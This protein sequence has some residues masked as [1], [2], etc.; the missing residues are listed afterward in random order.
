MLS[1]FSLFVG[2][3]EGMEK[4]GLLLESERKGQILKAMSS[5]ETVDI[6][7]EVRKH[8][9]SKDKFKAEN[10]RALEALENSIT[11]GKKRRISFTKYFTTLLAQLKSQQKFVRS[12]LYIFFRLY[13]VSVPPP[14][15][16]ASCPRKDEDSGAAGCSAA[17]L[18]EEPQHNGAS[19]PP[20]PDFV[21][22]LPF[23]IPRMFK[24]YVES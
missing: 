22:H 15:R 5:E 1:A 19:F 20:F 9:K 24:G 7:E 18:H 16:F 2:E 23:A 13:V 4:S 8:A 6:Y 21:P 17:V 14:D 12:V 10:C 3:I 11:N